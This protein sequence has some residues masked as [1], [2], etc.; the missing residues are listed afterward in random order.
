[1]ELCKLC[2][3]SKILQKNSSRAR[4]TSFRASAHH[5]HE[6]PSCYM[7]DCGAISY[8]AKK[9]PQCDSFLLP[10]CDNVFLMLFGLFLR[11][12]ATA[13]ATLASVMLYRFAD[14][15]N[16]NDDQNG[17]YNHICHFRFLSS[18]KPLSCFFAFLYVQRFCVYSFAGQIATSSCLA[19]P[20]VV[21]L[22]TQA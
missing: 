11:A 3:C 1:M 9:L 2:N 4:V 16:C 10:F 8:I 18:L 15:K 21:N 5:W 12:A 19:D 20:K 14:R 22:I 7:G 17:N 13:T 6:V